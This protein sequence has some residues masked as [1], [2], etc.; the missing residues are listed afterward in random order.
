MV[1]PLVIAT[2]GQHRPRDRDDPGGQHQAGEDGSLGGQHGGP[3]RHRG[4]VRLREGRPLEACDRF[5]E[6]LALYQEI[7]DKYQQARAHDGLARAG[8]SR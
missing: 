2:P 4:D 5:Q 8:R 1:L 6:A 3:A 7:G